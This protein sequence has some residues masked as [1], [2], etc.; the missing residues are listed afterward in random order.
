M[1][2]LLGFQKKGLRASTHW[3]QH[4]I[5]HAVMKGTCKKNAKKKDGKVGF[6]KG[7]NNDGKDCHK[8]KEDRVSINRTPVCNGVQGLQMCFAM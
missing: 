3:Q 1:A 7:D 4:P 2:S 6:C 8:G 5:A